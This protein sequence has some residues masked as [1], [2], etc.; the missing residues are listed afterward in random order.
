M[1][2]LVPSLALALMRAQG[3]R[4]PVV[5]ALYNIP[6]EFLGCLEDKECGLCRLCEKGYGQ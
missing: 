2:Q 1:R 6:A 5:K 3:L 4:I